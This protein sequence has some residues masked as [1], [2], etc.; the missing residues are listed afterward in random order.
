MIGEFPSDRG[1]DV[2]R[3]YNPDPD[4]GGTSY[5]RRGG[6]LYDA[7]EFDAEFF[8]ISPRE[9]LAMDPQQRLLLEASWE[10]F[11][12]AGVDPTS[13]RGSQTGVF[14]GV[15][16]GDYGRNAGSV[17]AELEGYL[18]TGSTGSV[19][20]GRLAYTFGLEG[21]AMTVDTACSSSLV[22]MHL[23][24]QALRSGECELALAGGV[25]VLSSPDF[26]ISFSR[27]RNLSVDGRCKS[28]GAGADGA[29]FSEGMGLLLL[30]RLSDAERAGHEVLAVVR[31]SAVNQ[32]GASNG[33][34]APNGPS[35][36]RV[37]G[38]ALASVGLST[39][40]VDAIEAHG[41]G[42]SLGDPIE[43]QALLATYGQDRPEGQPLWLGSIK[44]NMG[45]TQAAAGV[46][47]VIKMVMAMRHGVL[48]KTLHADEPSP[49]IDWSQGDVELLKKPVAWERNGKPRRAGVSS[50]G[51]S[52]TNA[53]V[54]LEEAPVSVVGDVASGGVGEDAGEEPGPAHAARIGVVPYLVSASS[55]DALEGQ[56]GRLRSFVEGSPDVELRG[57]GA[58]LAMRRSVLSHRAVVL[59]DG[60]EGLLAS[61]RALE[62]GEVTESV[63]R[64]VARGAG[65][66]AFLFP[67]QG[68]QWIG[69]GIG[70]WES[71]PVFAEQMQLC[72]EAFGS[73]FDWSLEDVLRGGDGAPSL[74]RVDVVQPALF[75]VMVSLA[76][77]WRSFGVEPAAVLGHSQGEIAAAYV[78]GGLSLDDAA[79]VVAS[80]SSVAAEELSDRGGMVSVA[81]PS[82][83]VE[84]ELERWGE[85]VSVAVVNGPASVVVAGE[86]EALDELLAH[87]EAQGVRSRRIPAAFASHS[88]QVERI[89]ERLLGE[90]ASLAPRAGEI[91]FYSATAC[92]Q[93]DT[94]GLDGDYWYANL[95]ETVR[96]Y[97]ATRVLLGDAVTT[98]VEMSPHPMLTVS[99]EEAIEAQ[100]IDRQTVAVLGSLKRERGDLDDFVLSLAKAHAAG[101]DVDWSSFFDARD[102]ERVTLP[103]YAFQRRRY[104][105]AS[106]T[107]VADASALGQ[108]VT[109]H[110]LLGAAL[111]LADAEDDWLF[112]GRLS[113]ATH[114]WL[115]DHAVMGTVLM[116]GTGFVELALAAG[117]H[118]GSEMVEE[119]TLQA[120]LLL[121]D[122]NAVQLQITVSAPD[123]EGHRQL[124]IYS[125]PQD[126]SGDA[127]DDD[128]IGHA[129]GVLG[130]GA[131]MGGPDTAGLGMAEEWPPPGSEELDSE[132]FYDRL[133]EAGY[134]YGPVFQG[135]R[136]VFREGEDL[137]AEVELDEDH[138][139]EAQAFCI[140]PAL[141]DSAL[142]AVL[143]SADRLAEIEVPFAFSGVR[144]FARGAGILRV[145]LAGDGEGSI[146]SLRAVDEL[147]DP[148]F[149]IQG[150]QA[151]IIDQS[152]LRSAA[153]GGAD[154]GLHQIEWV[155][156]SVPSADGS[157]LSVA[158]VGASTQRLFSVGIE[159]ECYPDLATLKDAIAGGASTPEIV[160]VEAAGVL[161]EARGAEEGSGGIVQD[162]GQALRE[163]VHLGAHRMLELL[164]EWSVSEGLSDARLVLVT[165]RAVG[166]VEG[167]RPN[168]TEAALVGLMR[169]AQSEHPGRFGVIDLDESTVSAEMLQGAL[170]LRETE[171]A[172]RRETIRAPRLARLARGD[173]EGESF[174]CTGTVLITGGTSGLGALMAQHLAA[175]H[176]AK[177]LLLVSR[178]GPEAAGVQ[179]LCDSLSE[180]G[181]EAR[182]AGCDVADREQ[183]R[184][185][186][187][188]IP[189]EYSL[190]GVI[191]AAGVLDDGLIESLDADRLSRVLAPKV[192]AAINLHEL[193]QQAELSEFV[194]F[195]SIAASMGSPGQGNYAA[196]NA[197]LDALAANRRADGLPGVSLAWGAWDRATIMTASL[198]ESDR[199]R[200]E[201]I[202][203]LP[204]SDE[205]GL[206]LFDL[207]CGVEEALVLPVRLNMSTLRA[208][209]KA[210]MLPTV[211]RGLVRVP[212]RQAS[213]A[214][215]SLARRLES[216]PESEWNSI[217]L[218]LVRGHVAGV[219]GYDSP[220][221]VDPGRAFKELGFDSLAAV[222]LRNRLSQA[223]GLQLP[224][225]LVF[226]HPTPTIVAGFVRSKVEGVKHG[227]SVVRRS[228]ARDGEPVAIVGMSCRFPGGV[229]SPREL[230]ELIASGGDAISVFPEDRGWGVERLYD[231]DPETPGTTYTRHGGFVY[232]AGDF[233][234]EFFGIGP[235]EALAMDPQQRLLLEG[236]WEAFEDAGILPG[237][238]AGSDTGVFAGV[239]YQDYGLNPGPVSAEL[240]GYLGT[241]NA[242][243]VISGRVAYV[244]GLE[245]PAMTVDT[246]CSSSLVALHS[247]CLA[248]RAGECSLALAGGVTVLSRPTVYTYFARQRGLSVDG[249]CKSFGAGA[250]GAGF[251]EGMGLLLLERLSDAER[252]GH[253]VLAVVRGS[254]VNQDGASN[255]LTAPNG[256]SQQRVI[257]QALGSVGLSP[258]EVD[259]VEAHGTGTTLG[260]PIEA[261]ALLATYGQDRP[262]GRPLW[263]GSVKSNLGHTQAAAGVAGVI[264]MVMALRNGV[265]PK[266]LHAD[267]PSP[268]IDWSEG[269][270]ELLHES[271]AWERN[272][273][274]RRAG[275]SSFG[276]SG[277]NAHVILEEAPVDVANDAASAG[278]V[279]GVASGRVGEDAGEEG[280]PLGVTGVGVVPYLVSASSDRALEG[281][282]GRLRSFVEGSPDVELRG[283]GA[284]LAMRRSVLSH[285]AVVLA[286]G[287]E[288]L[289]ASL[290]ALERGE[291][292][293]SVV[294]GVARGSG[295]AAFLF[296]GQGSQ[297]VGM[298]IGL[299]ESAPVFAEQMQLC[300]EAFGSYFDWSLE[301]VLR[302]GDGAPSLE[303]VD[304]VQPA[305]FSVMVSLAALWRSFGVEPA[306]V[307]GHSQGEIAAA[308]VAG[309]L[310][311]D[312]AV[313]VV[314]SRSTAVAEELSGRGGMVSVALP[315][316][317]VEGELERWG[318]RVSVA[319][320]NGPASV[321]VAGENE[322]LDEL[323]AHYEAQGVRSRRIPVDYASHSVQVERIKE[324][325]LG[326]LA[327]LAPRAGE[328][329]FY[330]ATA[331]KQIDTAGLDGDY[332]YANLRETVRFY[333]ATRV[334]LGDA[335]TTFVEMSPHP[336]LTVSVEEAIEAQEID[337]QTVA[338]LGSLK[339]GQ[340][341]RDDF[342]LSLA[343][344]HAAG[345]EVDWSSFFDGR[346]AAGV[347][348]P[349]YAFQRRRYWLRSASAVTDASALGQSIAEHPLLGAAL[350]LAGEEDAWLF[351]GRFSGE[352]HPWLKD[353]AVMDSMLMPGTGFLEL[354]L[355]AGEYVGSEMVEELTLQ[356]P[357]LLA[358]DEAVQLQITVSE[359]D[360]EGRR[361]IEIYARP[362]DSSGD[363]H[364]GGEW[365][366]HAAGVLCTNASA[367]VTGPVGSV[368][369]DRW[370]PV[371]AE[372]LDSE[373]FYDRLAEAGYGYGPVFQGL[374]RVFREGEDL[375]AEVEL[376]EDHRSEAQAFCIHPALS[377]SALHAVLLSADRLAEIEVP[378]AFSG[379]RLFARGA[380]ILRVHLAGDGEGSISS[381]RAVDELGDPVFSIQGM[382]ARI[383]DQSQLRSAARGGADDGL[384]QIE[385][386]ELSV[387]SADGSMLSVAAV[388]ASTQRLFSVGIELECYPDLATLKDAIAGGASTPEIVLVEA[389]G[390][391]AE[392]RGAEE[393]SGGI[394]QDE[395]QALRESVHLGAHR[396]LELLQEW[397][398][399]EGLSDARLVLVTDRAVGAVEG[400][401]PNLTEAALVGLMRSAQS[402]HP[403][404]FGVIDLDESTVSA[405]M[406]QG[407]LSLRETELA[408]R[409]ETIR[410][411]RL[412]RL[413]RGDR[414]GESFDCTGT[415]L[416]T[417]G[418]SGLGALMAQ[419]L[420]AEHGA[421]RLLL[422]SRS[423][424]EAAGV[425]ELCD[426]L[427][428]LGC[429]ARVAGCDVADRE[430]LRELIDTIPQEYSLTGVIHAAGV[431]DDGLI[432]SLDAD[433]LSRV[434]APK[435]DAAINLHELTQQAELSEFV[436][437]SSIAASM[438]SPGQGNYAAANAF[439]DALAANRRADGLPGVS[440]A[441]GAWDR[442][443][444][445]TASLT[446]SDRA[447]FE[448]IGILPLSDEQGL[449]LF[450]LA[451]GV[452]EALVLPVRLNMSTLR[453]QAKA[454]MLPTVLRGLVRV[455]TRQASDA[456]GSLARRLESAPESEWNSIILD[457]VR[458]HVAGVLGYDSPGEVDPGRAFKELGFDSL[459]AVELRNRLSQATGLQLPSTL[460][461]DHPTPTI[462]AEHIRTKV[463]LSGVGAPAI[464]TQLDK[465]EAALALLTEDAGERGRIKGRLQG[466]TR[467]VQSLL[468]E[469]SYVLATVGA[470]AEDALESATDDEVFE[471]LDKRRD[472]LGYADD[473]KDP[474]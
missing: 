104:W 159:L 288:G 44:S 12:D 93:I 108:S 245:G 43:A 286:D 170:S 420:A 140:H 382:Q 354:A 233:D 102:A 111:H 157:M 103:T 139:S 325:L 46:A 101:V 5:T 304:V 21:P 186:I 3:L 219:L 221:E 348:L 311:L 248:L 423:G 446:E 117:Q 154:D 317:Q 169:S 220:G 344:A 97:E 105:L 289:L 378:F 323:L 79:R 230:W 150:M 147:G 127:S 327:S 265:L 442:A 268:L 448:R 205:Q 110:P 244:Y 338:V 306:V 54:I 340:G 33:L 290:R 78:A 334:L 281:Q 444:I 142:H 316:G 80:R 375:F 278:V 351:T 201:R 336:M 239:M 294:R 192:D 292:T 447:R 454:G 135:L 430:Q 128:W 303:R 156:L 432:E 329:P 89:K 374:R 71:A 305:L 238:L 57:V 118:V 99:V 213:D 172:I 45:H 264:K 11:E 236:A 247:A 314:A 178:S 394:V 279:G 8:S 166:A 460:V 456:G 70:L 51:I 184:E 358:G 133:A 218:D 209:A 276:I 422:V 59:A 300:A 352:S 49:L 98:F 114:P 343:K 399:S 189:Q 203:I 307:L 459:A 126:A 36:Q 190:T 401:R 269:D 107:G 143:L 393:G 368:G 266:T 228:V 284:A 152:Q 298:G 385:W 429:E 373:Y 408:I 309:G 151:R 113:L 68:A 112:T 198:T 412:A 16:Y 40:D 261:Q 443:T 131:A 337:R 252:A 326:E 299:W 255:G 77:L 242:G 153:R 52:G 155:E 349:T 22:A 319:V 179:E 39:V 64:G 211:L 183:L 328:I 431:L 76:A 199:A 310:S 463:A 232:D 418:T 434:L 357:L 149:S 1:W 302:G 82:G 90:L 377:D 395:G 416:I 437:F 462:V 69:M 449:E 87:Y 465:L 407:A 450:D 436:L 296:S 58:A 231:A 243:S 410:A 85:R 19:I 7:A 26:F 253:E 27:Q 15:M 256:P 291:V 176:G 180:L 160:L 202:G 48:P 187:D 181:C 212:T 356:A 254:A 391:L 217:I 282:A 346:D 23:A 10:A 215:G 435:V 234:A 389:A 466:L 369:D 355:A 145:H 34:T 421:K 331:C 280:S 469:D 53:H 332:W 162:E 96:F 25:T 411:P 31:G 86:N 438:G 6:F 174:D 72:A 383:I 164:Q 335:V 235:R 250:D 333:E 197:F 109:D 227:V 257:G 405:E 312:D 439:L 362:D 415:V 148:V 100:E 173:R 365:T 14:T 241:G 84:G 470:D 196:A 468:A 246:A 396:M 339:R 138:R 30:E 193:T 75:S 359:P 267:E 38:Q 210:G 35:Q 381:L 315:S 13:L 167:D 425:Q 17:P 419:H 226:D 94:A 24:L 371:D 60:R 370:P 297:W 318:E 258:G 73:Y 455:P 65:R 341:G 251:S 379:V 91:P 134:G 225:T 161:A 293:E 409:R 125:R 367:P 330:S 458:G 81:L 262:E 360:P 440:L 223:T 345:V 287:R 324:R 123:E 204:L 83:Q 9:A 350:H 129:S 402:E 216:A 406:L 124:T 263:L 433:R 400:D 273:K 392:A 308:Y 222:E 55:D 473:E 28:F 67:G 295:R 472:D 428:E 177:R 426:S 283:V 62:R 119:L 141:S 61:L 229:S 95:R 74:E 175:E 471:L 50:F 47:G 259:V 137:F 32:D 185:L 92:K 364:M 37:I 132:Y 207:A 301:D 321:V 41:T 313:R 88:A 171:L 116:P 398:V 182:V 120:P 29:G 271:V 206:E 146:S 158:A 474:Q 249:R 163:S 122:D 414:E 457:L 240:E 18:G 467:R 347:T 20:S 452:E 144:L 270:V 390:V 224:S 380:G 191:H 353:H 275:V 188:T 453:A 66:V 106:E 366:C 342:V 56:A 285:R 237:S 130:S 361:E 461:F 445:M 363:T 260:D 451:C 165:D 388:G 42:T 417:G 2:E 403:G 424:P 195:S 136:R 194:L 413:A 4:H 386:V 272:G 208:Q 441:W 115:R 427:S 168:L 274:P 214:G 376:D 200:F 464:D 397:S 277:T 384:H 320:V 322:A 372:E 387:P 404:R 121:S 63:V